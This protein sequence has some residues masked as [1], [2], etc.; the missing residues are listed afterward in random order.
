MLL[1]RILSFSLSL[2]VSARSKIKRQL[3]HDTLHEIVENIHSLDSMVNNLLAPHLTSKNMLLLSNMF[4]LFADQVFLDSVLAD[5]ALSDDVLKVKFL[6][7]D[8][9]FTH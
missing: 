5:P 2:T 1:V 6:P 7:P 8:L 4:A 3:V 9:P